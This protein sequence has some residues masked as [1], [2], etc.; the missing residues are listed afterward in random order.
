MSCQYEQDL[1][2]A[3]RQSKQCEKRALSLDSYRTKN[4]TPQTDLRN[5]FVVKMLQNYSGRMSNKKSIKE[6]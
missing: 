4:E 6:D 3:R 5:K 1:G 2:C